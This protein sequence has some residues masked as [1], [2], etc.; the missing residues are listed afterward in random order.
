MET[1][2]L[3]SKGQLVIPRQ[4]RALAHL[5]AGDEF[6]VNY[7]QGEIRLRPLNRT[8]TSTIDDVAGCLAKFPH[9]D[10][11]D[12]EAEKI[13]KARLLAQDMTT[14]TKPKAVRKAAKSRAK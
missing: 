10:M 2:T 8:K 5:V 13:A 6:A 12:E 7:V 9:T 14:M 3:S 1:A 4:V 11:S